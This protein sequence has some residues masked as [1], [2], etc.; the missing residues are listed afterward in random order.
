VV[1]MVVIYGRPPKTARAPLEHPFEKVKKTLSVKKLIS[2]TL[3]L[4]RHH[5]KVKG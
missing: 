3:I 2:G 4:Y 5:C 1:E